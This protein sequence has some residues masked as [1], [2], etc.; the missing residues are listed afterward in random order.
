M[1]RS[2]RRSDLQRDSR[3]RYLL[4]LFDGFQLRQGGA[5]VPLP[6][7]VQRVLAFIALHDRPLRRAYV[8]GVLWPNSSENRSS[9]SLRSTLWRLGRVA[10]KSVLV[11]GGELELAREVTVDTREMKATARELLEGE[12]NAGELEN[13]LPTGELLPGWYEDWVVIERERLRQLR[14]HALELLCARLATAGR[15]GEAVEAGL[16]AIRDEPL[17]ET[18][19]RALIQAHLAEGNLVEAIRQYRW[20]RRVLWDELRLT[21]SPETKRLVQGLRS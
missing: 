8:A 19:H 6:L 12:D 14:L 3:G 18:T 21:P 17:R 4:D 15:F 7:S 13:V 10:R 9:A 2:T 1:P 16:A 11:E 5:A 20:Y